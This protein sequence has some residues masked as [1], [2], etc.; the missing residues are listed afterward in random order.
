M[1]QSFPTAAGFTPD[2]ARLYVSDDASNDILAFNVAADGALSPIAGSPFAAPGGPISI[3]MT[4]DGSRL[5][6]ANIGSDSVSEIDLS[7][8]SGPSSVRRIPVGHG[9]EGIAISPDGSQVWVGHRG[10]GLAVIV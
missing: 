8:A 3:N 7:G 4:A 5:Y 6:T 9:P 2:G 10:G 1:D